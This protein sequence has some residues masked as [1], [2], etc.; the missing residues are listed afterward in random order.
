MARQRAGPVERKE[1]ARA[2]EAVREGGEDTKGRVYEFTKQPRWQ[3][4]LLQTSMISLNFFEG[5]LG[6]GPVQLGC[7]L[8]WLG[9]N[10][11]VFSFLPGVIEAMGFTGK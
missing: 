9:G 2:L 10:S 6:K 4:G 1:K 5:G 8:S 3:Q 11:K 7:Q